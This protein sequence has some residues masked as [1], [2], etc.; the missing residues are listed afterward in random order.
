MGG[1]GDSSLVWSHEVRYWL[2]VVSRAHV[3]RGIALGIAQIGHGKRG[4]LARMNGGDCSVFTR[5]AKR[6]EPAS[7]CRRSRRLAECPTT[8]SGR[9][10]RGQAVQR[11]TFKPF[12]LTHV[13][14]VLLASPAWLN[15][16][17]H[18]TQRQLA[19]HAATDSMMTSQVLRNLEQRGL[20]SRARHPVDNRAPRAQRHPPGQA[21]ANHAVV[22]SKHATAPSS[23]CSARASAP[24]HV[25]QLASRPTRR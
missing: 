22:A 24:C 16:D 8:R 19:D 1:P 3:R 14:F 5:R 25:A 9:S 21:L 15:V 2:G 13:Q 11:A 12:E 7:R 18:V 17:G 23:P 10:T 6:A 20:V 4:G